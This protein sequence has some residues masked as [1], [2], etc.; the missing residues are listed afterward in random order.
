M[1]KQ[2]Y[3]VVIQSED[4]DSST[5]EVIQ[6][7]HFLF[8]SITIYNQFNQYPIDNLKIEISN[9]GNSIYTWYYTKGLLQ[10]CND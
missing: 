4:N 5:D 8:P 1:V 10:L 6:W 2:D 3:K 7:L 9:K